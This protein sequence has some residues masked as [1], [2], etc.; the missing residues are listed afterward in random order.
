MILY[1]SCGDL[2]ICCLRFD[3][4]DTG[5]LDSIRMN[6]N[7]FFLNNCMNGNGNELIGISSKIIAYFCSRIK[8]V[9]MEHKCGK[10]MVFIRFLWLGKECWT[11]VGMGMLGITFHKLFF[12]NISVVWVECGKEDDLIKL[13]KR[14]YYY[15]TLITE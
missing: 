10:E 13:I 3:Y 4:M 7:M 6:I 1:F 11:I 9:V 12:Q 14:Y 5:I 15:Y 2:C 8:W